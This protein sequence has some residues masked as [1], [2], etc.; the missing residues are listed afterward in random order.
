M[1]RNRPY[2]P[3]QQPHRRHHHSARP[4]ISQPLMRHPAQRASLRW[5]RHRPHVRGNGRTGFDSG[6]ERLLPLQ[7]PRRRNGIERT[8]A[9]LR[10][11]IDRTIRTN[12]RSRAVSCGRRRIFPT[13]LPRDGIDGK[14]LLVG[15]RKRVE[16]LSVGSE[17]NVRRLLITR[18]ADRTPGIAL[19]RDANL[20]LL[21]R[22]AF[23]G[24]GQTNRIVAGSG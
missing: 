13:N 14:E 22:S 15:L 2:R 24:D 1:C 23:A 10:S 3:G 16:G 6:A 7:C 4:T 8:V 20:G 17:D 12:S 9:V 5:P 18:S 21:G 19:N 11:E